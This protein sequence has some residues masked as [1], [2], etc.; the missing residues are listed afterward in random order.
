MI[1]DLAE[2]IDSSTP[3]HRALVAQVPC[4]LNLFL[5]VTGKRTDGYHELDTIMIAVNLCDRMVVETC[6][7]PSLHLSVTCEDAFGAE[8]PRFGN[9][10]LAWNIPSDHRNL[11]LRALER[12][13]QELHIHDGAKV[14]LAKRIPAQ[15]GLGGGS[16]DAAAALALGSLAWTGRLHLPILGKIASELGSDLNFFL[17]GWNGSLWA[18]RCTGRGEYVRPVPG[19]SD[20]HFVI[21]HPPEGC[22]TKQIFQSLDWDADRLQTPVQSPD[23]LL[24]ALSTGDAEGVGRMLYNRLEPAAEANNRWI[25]R[26]ARWI[27]RYNPLGQCLSGSGSARFCL[28]STR[29]EAEKI[30]SELGSSGEAR[31]YAV[32]TWRSPSLPQQA[33]R[34]GFAS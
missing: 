11:V 24:A 17:E 34:L 10:D 33:I 20:L 23:R 2:P 6:P 13:R 28:C 29:W 26:T 31:V 5:E 19:A 16:A 3:S 7:D 1:L 12:L 25:G 8:P 15:A 14:S 27:D 30:A 32:S 22:D 4:K 9:E 18:G 21:I